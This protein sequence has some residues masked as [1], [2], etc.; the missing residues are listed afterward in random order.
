MYMVNNS[1]DFRDLWVRL[2][3][4]AEAIEDVSALIGPSDREQAARLRKMLPGIDAEIAVM[5]Q[6]ISTARQTEKG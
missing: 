5:V 4:A 1:G 6:K 2:L 3:R